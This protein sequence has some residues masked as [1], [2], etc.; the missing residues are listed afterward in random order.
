MGQPGG[1]LEDALDGF[2][3]LGNNPVLLVSFLGTT[4]ALCMAL[5]AGISLTR[6][7]SAVHRIVIDSGRSVFIWAV[8]LAAK[9]QTFQLLQIIGFLI[10][11]IGV[12]IFNDV[13]LGKGP[14]PDNFHICSYINKS[15][16]ENYLFCQ[17]Y[18][19]GF[20]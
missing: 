5:L 2:V 6:K 16:L 18:Q 17:N 15:H 4:V 14:F 9:W 7:L 12:L 20:K 19:R 13:L 10:M 1:Q 3:Q 11:S 8:S